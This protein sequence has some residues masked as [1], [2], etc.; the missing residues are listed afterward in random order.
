MFLGVVKPKQADKEMR[1]QL[2]AKLEHLGFSAEYNDDEVQDVNRAKIY[3]AT[4]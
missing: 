1:R 4:Q 2:S 3:A